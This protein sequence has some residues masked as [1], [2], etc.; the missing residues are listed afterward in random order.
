MA[1][2]PNFL[3]QIRFRGGHDITIDKAAWDKIGG[4]GEG[5]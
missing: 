3:S 4:P 5:D 1:A 2:D